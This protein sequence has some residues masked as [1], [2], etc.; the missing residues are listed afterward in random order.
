M[1]RQTIIVFLLVVGVAIGGIYV[2]IAADLPGSDMLSGATA[3]PTH[4]AQQ[5]APEPRAPVDRSYFVESDLT[6]TWDWSP[7]LTAQQ[8]FAVRLWYG[9]DDAN[10]REAW[11]SDPA[12]QA[13]ETIDGYLQ[14]VGDFHWQV[15]VINL[16]QDGVFASMGSEW[17]VIQ[18][19]QR[20]RHIS[21]T[22]VLAEERSPVTELILAMQPADTT[23]LIDAVRHF[24]PE[25]S[26]G[27][28]QDAGFDPDY[29]DA[30]DMMA[31]YAAGTGDKP[32]LLC[33]GQVTSAL[34][35]L[36]EL[37]IV[38][39]LIFLYSDDL[40]KIVEHTVLEVFN[41]DT[42][43]WEVHDVYSDRYF[44]DENGDRASIER[45]VFGDLAITSVCTPDGD[46]TPF[47]DADY[48]FTTL[49]EAFR[50]G[51]VNT[52]WVN[53]DRFDVSKRFITNG[54]VNLAEYKTGNP[55]DFTF[56]FDSW[57]HAAP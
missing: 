4:S 1:S 36:A 33:D 29:G 38:S 49:F 34:T 18:T 8:T 15:A 37:G 47:N 12:F 51:H 45:L 6:L 53:P 46:C 30:L 41:P 54:N 9:A 24:V 7:P 3:T 13:A 16:D 55:R 57:E 20:V 35:V 32:R 22:A 10:Y 50:Y 2:L 27:E 11:V 43:H 25:H 19:L 5:T 52:F 39:R 21:P 56:H 44:V 31:A 14:A 26:D 17:S 28:T 23:A 40:D 48:G 42:Q